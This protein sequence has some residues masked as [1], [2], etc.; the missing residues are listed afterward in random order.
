MGQYKQQYPDLAHYN[1]L[2]PV[3]DQDFSVIAAD[4]KRELICWILGMIY[5]FVIVGRI[6]LF[7]KEIC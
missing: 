4:M 1:R 7:V 3:I 2:T 6:K 5:L